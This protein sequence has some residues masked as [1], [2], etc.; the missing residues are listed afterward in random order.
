MLA[1][2]PSGTSDAENCIC[3][4][5]FNKT[6]APGSVRNLSVN[7]LFFD[8]SSEYPIVVNRRR[9]SMILLIQMRL[10]FSSDQ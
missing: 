1:C 5:R 8:E 4:Q 7:A 9:A 3:R 2:A 10:V 6:C